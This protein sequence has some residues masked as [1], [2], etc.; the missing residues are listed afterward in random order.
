MGKIWDF[1]ENMNEYLYVSSI[2]NYELLYMNKKMREVYGFK[3]KDELGEVCI[4]N[5]K[6]DDINGIYVDDDNKSMCKGCYENDFD[7]SGN[8]AWSE[9]LVT[10]KLKRE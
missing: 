2:D 1:F 5:V 3:I 6:Y 9:I 8:K 7:Q 10:R 4:V